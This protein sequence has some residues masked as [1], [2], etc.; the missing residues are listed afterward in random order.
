VREETGYALRPADL[1][2]FA[3][4]WRFRLDGELR[5]FY[6]G[7]DEI[8]EHRFE[9]RVPERAPVLAPDEHE[10]HRWC[11]REEALALL[12]WPSNREALRLLDARLRD[13]ER[14]C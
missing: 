1:R 13:G 12:H 5:R 7:H 9:G 10:A 4:T 3:P 8:E 11:G 6:P 14:A 2:E